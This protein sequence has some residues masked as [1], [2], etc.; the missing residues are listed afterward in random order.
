MLPL[1]KVLHEFL[2]KL[3]IRIAVRAYC[4]PGAA[5]RRLIR[6]ISYSLWSNQALA[7]MARQ[8]S[9]FA[10]PWLSMPS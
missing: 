1:E 4:S 3:S 7:V 2:E 6:A 5:L 8:A 10:N 9:T